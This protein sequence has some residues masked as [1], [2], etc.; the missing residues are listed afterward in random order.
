MKFFIAIGAMCLLY[1]TALYSGIISTSSTVLRMICVDNGLP[2]SCTST[3]ETSEMSSFATIYA[4]AGSIGMLLTN[5]LITAL[6][7]RWGR[8]TIILLVLSGCL[9]ESTMWLLTTRSETGFFRE[10]WRVLLPI[11]SFIQSSVGSIAIAVFAIYTIVADWTRFRTEYRTTLFA[12]LEGGFAIS[13]ILGAQ[14]AALFMSIDPFYAFVFSWSLI[15]T[16]LILNALLLEDTTPPEVRNRKIDWWHANAFGALLIL[17]PTRRTRALREEDAHQ[18]Y[19]EL[20]QE[21]LRSK[22]GD[23]IAV[24]PVLVAENTAGVAA[25][26]N[27][28][29]YIA[30]RTD[31]EIL[32]RGVLA[33]DDYA[34]RDAGDAYGDGD[35]GARMR[36]T[37]STLTDNTNRNKHNAGKGFNPALSE[38]LTGADSLSALTLHAHNSDG[39]LGD[40][41][42]GAM[43][44]LQSATP[45]ALELARHG[46]ALPAE[47]HGVGNALTVLAV[48]AFIGTCA[49]VG[50]MT[51]R[52]PYMKQEYNA[53]DQVVSNLATIEA[54]ARAT[55][56][57]VLVPLLH[58]FISSRVAELRTVQ[59]LLF[60]QGVVLLFFMAANTLWQT[61]LIFIIGGFCSSIPFGFL[62]GLLSTEVGVLLQGKVLSALA[63]VDIFTMLFASTGFSSL[64]AHTNKTFPE[65]VYVVCGFF[66]ITAALIPLLVSDTKAM[67]NSRRKRVPKK[68]AA[69]VAAAD[70]EAN[71]GGFG[72]AGDLAPLAPG[73]DSD[74]GY[75]N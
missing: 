73:A 44:P 4:G 59:A 29:L 51:V 39:V 72:A 16:T 62:R 43:S 22:I 32:A 71:E 26:E 35:E 33:S 3:N 8:K 63:S 69:D 31:T 5:T 20:C 66:L 64:F 19:E 75:I 70:A 56:T 68:S 13:G 1:P 7:D 52:I 60:M 18:S 27:T 25:P 24:D 6:A 12:C 2:A 74:A 49:V 65:S 23:P 30:P 57:F 34:G 48:A 54:V 38:S 17:C 47:P 67:F 9:F 55:G 45:S 11:A 15:A 41:H 58:K 40:H 28:G 50:L 14:G 53:S 61:F 37:N 46:I 42:D 10:N 36:S 21:L